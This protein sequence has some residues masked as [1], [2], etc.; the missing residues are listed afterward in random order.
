MS[1]LQRVLF[2]N[3][4]IRE[5]GFFR[6][7]DVTAE[8]EVSMRT[9]KRDIDFIRLEFN[10]SIIYDRQKKGYVCRDGSFDLSPVNEKLFLYYALVKSISQCDYY[11]PVVSRELTAELEDA[12]PDST[13]D[14]AWRFYYLH[15]EYESIDPILLHKF[16]TI[17]TRKTAIRIDYTNSRSEFKNYI[18]EP[19]AIIQY[20]GKWYTAAYS[21]NH[22]ELRIFSMNRISGIIEL[23][24][25]YTNAITKDEVDAFIQNGFGINKQKEQQY[26]IIRFYPPATLTLKRTV[27]HKDQKV[28]FSLLPDGM[29]I[30]DFKIPY[31][32]HRELIGRVLRYGQYAEI[33]E[34]AELRHIWLEEI[35]A[36]SVKYTGIHNP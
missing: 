23:G 7:G 2:I 30:M 25:P 5:Y 9:V 36:M 8:F 28:T 33:L 13:K 14:A 11:I 20:S 34:P 10:T 12:M 35:R 22:G 19:Q 17:F 24:T 4:Q 1:R 16:T 3:N 31:G 27:L 26:A 18:I 15:S 29:E 21:Q 6:I 32:Y